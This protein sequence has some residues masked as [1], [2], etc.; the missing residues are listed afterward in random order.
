SSARG[1]PYQPWLSVG[2]VV[3]W[4]LERVFPGR[5]VRVDIR[6]DGGLCLEQAVLRL[7]RLER[8][9]EALI[10]FAG[11]NEFQA[12]YGWSRDVRHCR[13]GGRARPRAVGGGGRRALRRRGVPRPPL[14]RHYGS[15]P[16]PDHA[17]RELVDHPICTPKEYAFLREDYARRVDAVAAYCGRIGA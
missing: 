6:A 10:V 2:Q 4:Q 11:H 17:T 12:R 8:R 13:G 7:S 1:E 5:E 3:G 14:D 16:T 15:T 9:P